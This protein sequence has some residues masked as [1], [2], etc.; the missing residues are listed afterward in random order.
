MNAAA[1]PQAAALPPLEG[2]GAIDPARQREVVAALRAVLPEHCL[3]YREE[4]TRPYECDALTLYRQLPMAVALPETVE[5]V[6][7]V[8]RIC[9]ALG[10]PVVPRGAGTS[11]SGGAMPHCA[12][13]VLSMAKFNRILAIDSLARTATVEPGVRN[14]AIS[15][16]AAPYGLYYA[17]DPSSQIGRASCRERV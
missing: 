3:L 9:H 12:G 2:V 15:E 5:Q 10:V 17:P 14:L 6:R 7:Q 8:L 13:V 11:L 4:D 16:A 1:G